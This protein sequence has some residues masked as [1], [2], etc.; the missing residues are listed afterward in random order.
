LKET[1]KPLEGRRLDVA[2]NTTKLALAEQVLEDETRVQ[3][4]T[5]RVSR[6][7]PAAEALRRIH[8]QRLRSHLDAFYEHGTLADV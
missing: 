1:A 5:E 6:I 4:A 8:V 2:R 3:N 7:G